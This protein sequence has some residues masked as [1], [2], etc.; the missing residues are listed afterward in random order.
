MFVADEVQLVQDIFNCLLRCKDMAG[1]E[2]A[3]LLVLADLKETKSEDSGQRKLFFFFF[4]FSHGFPHA[5]SI[6]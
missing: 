4:S 6:S 3:S 1:F 2:V 5:Q